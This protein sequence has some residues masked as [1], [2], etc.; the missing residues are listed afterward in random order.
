MKETLKGEQAAVVRLQ[1]LLDWLVSPSSS[2][3]AWSVARIM[4]L[5]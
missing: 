1:L 4:R 5:K 3:A 2:G